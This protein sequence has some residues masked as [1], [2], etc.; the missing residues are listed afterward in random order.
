M[1]R[2]VPC[3]AGLAIAALA[4][5]PALA[6][7]S[8]IEGSEED[9]ELGAPYFGEAKD[10]RGLKP[11]E[12]VRIS[13]Q[14][15]GNPLPVLA[16]TDAEGRFRIPGFGKEVNSDD[17]TITCAKSGWKVVETERRKLAK[18]FDSPVEIECLLEKN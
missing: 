7:G 14:R 4:A 15:K 10:I 3:L 1:R 12:G 6:G 17:V 13:A 9:K 18:D 5:G 16:S 8:D 2:L 11:L